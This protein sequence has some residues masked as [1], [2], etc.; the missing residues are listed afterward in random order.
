LQELTM[1]SANPLDPTNY[2]TLLGVGQ[3]HNGSGQVTYSFPTSIPGYYTSNASGT[4]NV[5]DY[6]LASG[7]S[8]GLDTG[9]KALALLAISRFN[10][11]ANVNLVAAAPGTTGT[12][13]F[14][15]AD[16]GDPGLFGFVAD[17][18]DN[19][20]TA[21]T[22]DNGDVW[23]NK[24]PLQNA[25]AP[26]NTGWQTFLHELG[27]G[28]GLK[29]DFDGFPVLPRSLDNNRYTVMSYTVHPGQAAE[30]D[31]VAQWPA[32]LMLYDIQAMQH[33]YGANMTTRATN[34]TYFG[35]GANQ[36]FALADGGKLIMTIWDGGGEDEINASNQTGKVTIDL[37]P[38]H[39]STIGAIANNIAIAYGAGI[40]GAQSAWIEN[41]TGGSGNDTL[42]GND[43][44]NILSGGAGADTLRGG[45]G[46]DT[47]LGGSGIDKLYGEDGNDTLDGGSDNDTLS[48]GSGNDSLNGG[49][50]KD[51]LLGG[52]GIDT[53]IGGSDASVDTLNGGAGADFLYGGGGKDIFVYGSVSDSAPAAVDHIM[54][55]DALDVIN[56]KAIDAN[57]SLAADQAF[58]FIGSA[59]F[60]LQAAGQVR[61]VHIG[62]DTWVEVENTG[63]G[64]VDM[65]IDLVGYTANM[66][67]R[68]FLL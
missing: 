30:P 36:A 43:I 53:L 61:Y 11:V 31:A 17:F 40:A 7:T 5:G 42:T 55:F 21:G 38:G 45:L 4:L 27:H 25:A 52:D 10:E 62:P 2:L 28:L 48:G 9:Q 26:Y 51:V 65:A 34:T 1:A 3:W 19:T 46:H 20:F 16:F 15:S 8:I 60:A 59:A 12:V 63:D 44:D 66:I 68:D 6:T 33:L 54:D 22:G 57:L 41:A 35:P 32:T 67:A 23:I 49:S 24:M 47:L 18:P 64:I 29:H 56:L 39:F 50:G 14:A 37:N 13:T 58:L